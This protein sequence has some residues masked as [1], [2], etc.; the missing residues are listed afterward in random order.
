MGSIYNKLIEQVID[1]TWIIKTKYLKYKPQRNLKWP[2]TVFTSI[3]I[4]ESNNERI[5]G[6]IY[7][8]YLLYLGCLYEY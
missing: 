5:N 1:R 2:V 4:R 6:M 7:Y 3:V 8:S